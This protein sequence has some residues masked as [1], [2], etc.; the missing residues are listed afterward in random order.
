MKKL[1][2]LIVIALVGAS[3]SAQEIKWITFQEAIKAQKAN[4]KPIFMDVYTS[5][6]GPCKMLDQ[7]TFT[8]S[9]VI[10]QINSKFYAVKFNAEGNEKIE[11]AGKTF[12]NPNYDANRAGRNGMHEFTAFLRVPGYP[13]MVIIEKDGTIKKT[14][15]GYKV[16]QQLL[17]EIK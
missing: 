4:P 2:L 5:W 6:C 17:Q 1:I 13:S 7:N 3:A 9:A 16:P 14:L 12:G 11:F 15:V 10:E 8:D